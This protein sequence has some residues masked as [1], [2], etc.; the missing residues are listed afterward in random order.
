M[1]RPDISEIQAVRLQNRRELRVLDLT[2]DDYNR[3]SG[4]DINWEVSSKLRT[5]P[6]IAA[7][8]VKVREAND[9]F[10][11]EYI[12][13]QLLLQWINQNS[14]DGIRYSSTHINSAER[15]HEAKLYN[16]VIPVKSFKLYEGYC[17]K[18]LN[19][20]DSTEVL[21]MQV[22]SFATT[23]NHF[24]GQSSVSIEVNPDILTLELVRGREEMYWGTSFGE[25]EHALK[26]FGA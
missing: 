1:R 25:L 4:D 17:E 13:P 18:L 23:S 19:L 11:P 20:F 12:I 21:P 8:S 14:L 16:L 9:T 26:G 5:W 24:Y 2:T 15:I 10:K 7:C 22:L 6:L 3:K